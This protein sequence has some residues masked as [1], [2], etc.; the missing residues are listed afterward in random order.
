MRT[1]VVVAQP[2]AA[3]TTAPLAGSILEV[4]AQAAQIGFDAI[5]LT[6]GRP[7]EVDVDQVRAAVERHGL[8]VSSIATGRGYSVDGLSLGA[9][10]QGRRQGAVERMCQHVDLAARL[11]GA[12]RVI[13]G[14]IR[15]WARDN[16]GWAV[17]APRFREDVA[18][19]LDHAMARGVTVILE[20]ND[21]L[22]TD[23]YCAVAETVDFIKSFHCPQFKLQLDTMHLWNEGEDTRHAVAYG[24]EILA[25]VDISDVDRMAPDGAHFDFQTLMHAL[26]GVGYQDYLVFEYRQSPPADAARVG[27]QYIRG[28]LDRM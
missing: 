21:H 13:I 12:P 24:A 19:V 27:H 17:Y 1:S 11:G 22:E 8:A 25:Q 20:A 7:S 28:L 15:G 14:A 5:Q 18:R 23:A 2:E 16:G 10:D 9:L 6:V 4:A 26:K 3:G